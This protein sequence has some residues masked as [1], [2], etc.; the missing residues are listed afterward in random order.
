MPDT[1]DLIDRV[2][3]LLG[4]AD[5]PKLCNGEPCYQIREAEFVAI[6]KALI[7]AE[8]GLHHLQNGWHGTANNEECRAFC[9]ELRAQIRSLPTP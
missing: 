5:A 9:K 2:K 7:A 3:Y 6:A 8:M 4:C 1:P